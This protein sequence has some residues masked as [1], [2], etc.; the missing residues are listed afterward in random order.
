MTSAKEQDEIQVLPQFLTSNPLKP[1]AVT[2]IL[3]S[4][5]LDLSGSQPIKFLDT[6]DHFHFH[7]FSD[8][9]KVLRE[10]QEGS[11]SL[12]PLSIIICP[13]GRLPESNLTP[14]FRL[15]LYYK[16]LSEAYNGKETQ[17]QQDSWA[18][19]D[20]VLYGEIVTSTQTLLERNP[21]LLSKL[22]PPILSIASR[23]LAGR[24]RGTNVWYSP[25]GCLQF[26]LLLRISLAEFPASKLV[27]IQY[28]FGLAVVEACREDSILGKHGRDI[29]LKWPN[30]IYAVTGDEKKKIGGILVNT[31][32]LDGKVDVIIGCGLNVLNAPPLGSL[33]Q[34]NPN[35]NTLTLERT[36]ALIMARFA[37]MWEL[38]VRER[39]SFEPFLKLY[40]D[41]WMHSDQVITLTNKTPSRRVRIV[42]I[43]LDHGL[44]RTVPAEGRTGNFIDIQPDLNSFDVMAAEFMRPCSPVT[45]FMSSSN[46]LHESHGG[47]QPQDDLAA[48]FNK[49]TSAV[50]FYA[51]HFEHDVVRPAFA[52][53]HLFFKERPITATLVA[54]FSLLSFVPVL[55][56]ISASLFS[57]ATVVLVALFGAVLVSGAAIITFL[58]I[59]LFALF[60]NLFTALFF[61]GL[62]TFA[63]VLIRLAILVRE[64]GTDGISGWVIELQEFALGKPHVVE[65]TAP[66]S[67]SSKDGALA[68]NP[69]TPY[70]YIESHDEK[71]LDGHE[72]RT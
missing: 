43:T 71:T 23:Q 60:I 19:G 30:D 34:L 14:S 68:Q 1:L 54:I 12:R 31:S 33:S 48:Y 22:P 59:L 42:G 63:Y 72:T 65:D 17:D 67:S 9:E 70:A 32:F 27:F 49:S 36:A 46:C 7:H 47:H 56:F 57:I 13:D 10:A 55:V 3:D 45:K 64:R 62:I 20:V 8:R 61:T 69:G 52:N 28:L 2:R 6:H 21:R 11:Q 44:L 39:G 51:D 58:S 24:G 18:I 40:L 37:P 35:S 15:D 16:D 41:W 26:S 25:S 29:R 50:Q 53:S 66:A 5:A 38:F 4:F